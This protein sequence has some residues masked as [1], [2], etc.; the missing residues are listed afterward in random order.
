M[1]ASVLSQKV[2]AAAVASGLDPQIVAAVQAL[3]SDRV[4][5]DAGAV[6][7]FTLGEVADVLDVSKGDALDKL[8][9]VA[10][11]FWLDGQCFIRAGAA[12]AAGQAYCDSRS[13]EAEVLKI[14]AAKLVAVLLA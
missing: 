8:S 6:M 11:R 10:M 9:E 4:Q 2:A 5:N 7:S 13:I 12:W 14:D 3:V 1:Q